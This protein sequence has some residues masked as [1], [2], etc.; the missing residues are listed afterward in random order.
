LK[1]LNLM[2]PRWQN[3]KL[4]VGTGRKAVQAFKEV[5]LQEPQTLVDAIGLLDKQFSRVEH[6]M[7]PVS[8]KKPSE[9]RKINTKRK[10]VVTPKKR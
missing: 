4:P 7:D 6:D 3:K 1:S 2:I 5:S 10:A 8:P 9:P